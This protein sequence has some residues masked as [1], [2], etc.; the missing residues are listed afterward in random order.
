MASVPRGAIACTFRRAASSTRPADLAL[1]RR[2]YSERLA[3][4]PEYRTEDATTFRSRG[5]AFQP[6][7]WVRDALG[8]ALRSAPREADGLTA[9]TA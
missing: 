8:K 4:L 6:G 7:Q 5:F 2:M 3:T 9:R 1:G